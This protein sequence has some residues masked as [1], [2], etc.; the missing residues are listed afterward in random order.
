MMRM[1]KRHL[2]FILDTFGNHFEAQA[3]CHADDGSGDCGV[4]EIE[5][6]IANEQAM[7]RDQRPGN[8]DCEHFASEKTDAAGEVEL[9]IWG[10]RRSPTS[11]HSRRGP[12]R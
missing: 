4:I 11:S 7:Q 6:N 10:P 8:R 3:F 9:R 1:Q 12:R 5:S 2:R